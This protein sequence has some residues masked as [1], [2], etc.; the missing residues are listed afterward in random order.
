[1][2][3]KSRFYFGLFIFILGFLSPLAIPLVLKT[4]LSAG[5]KTAISGALAVGGPEI[6]MIIAGIIMGKENLAMVKA[7]VFLSSSRL[8]PQC[9]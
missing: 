4:N 9:L 7:K 8:P 1:M 5:I 3:S 2:Q 6:L